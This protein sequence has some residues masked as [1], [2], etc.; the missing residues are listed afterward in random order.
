VQQQQEQQQQQQTQP[1]EIQPQPVSELP[2][3]V[4]ELAAELERSPRLK[5]ALQEEAVRIQQAQQGAAAAQQ[6]YLQA[7]QQATAFAVQS[8]LAAFPEF[9][10][11]S[12]EQLPAALQVLKAS[13]PHRH[14]DAVQHLARVDQLGRALQQAKAQEQAQT[15]AVT[16]QWIQ[17]QDREVDQYLAKNESVETVRA[18]KDN[19]LKVVESYGIPEQEFRQAISQVPL[20]RSAPF[21]KM[22]FQLAKTHVLREQV[23]EKVAKPAVPVVQRPGTSQRGSYAESEVAAAREAFLRSPDDPRLAK[24]AANS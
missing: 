7:S 24:R 5:A 11:L 18:V 14:A 12:F 8:M 9:Q 16:Q 6:Q 3:E 4:A 17:Q 23:A 1:A 15:Q 2:P 21:Q 10:G 13:N 22:L 19:L 20:L